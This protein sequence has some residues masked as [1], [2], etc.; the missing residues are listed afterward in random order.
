MTHSHSSI[1]FHYLIPTFYFPHRVFTKAFIASIF[2]DHRKK[3]D[4]INYIFC[5]DKYLL[6]LNK[7]HLNHNYYT[8]IITFDLSNDSMITADVFISVERARENAVL[9]GNTILEEVIRLLIHGALHLC[10]F[11][12]K[13][14]K[15]SNR[16]KGFENKYLTHYLVSRETIKL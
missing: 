9:F 12:D 6:S 2:A 15:D 7:N 10:G 13:T 5:S 8:D 1:Y 4:T 11:K 3:I 16:M 14:K